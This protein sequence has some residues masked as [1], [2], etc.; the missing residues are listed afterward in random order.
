VEVV[1]DEAPRRRVTA[2]AGRRE[3]VLPGEARPGLRELQTQRVR[4]V[5]LATP[6]SQLGTVPHRDVAEL[7]AQGVADRARQERRAVVAAL[8]P[9]H[10]D[11]AAVEIDVLHPKRKRLHEAQAAPIKKLGDQAKRRAELLEER[12]DLAAAKDRR[13][14]LGTV[15]PLQTVEVRHRDVEDA[16]VQEDEGTEGLVLRRCGRATLHREMIE[17]KGDLRR[18]QLPRVAAPVEDDE[19]PDPAEV[20]LLGPGRVV[21]AP[22]GPV[23][24]FDEGHTSLSTRARLQLRRRQEKVVTATP[25]LDSLGRRGEN[26]EHGEVGGAGED[27]PGTSIAWRLGGTIPGIWE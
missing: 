23:D 2:R 5:D 18:P 21:E 15:G 19:G 20:R 11:L 1:E 9:A 22:E 3:D 4:E 24:G 12:D 13:E 25:G 8:A 27:D 10:H 17:E 16:A 6:S 14:M 26:G 7:H